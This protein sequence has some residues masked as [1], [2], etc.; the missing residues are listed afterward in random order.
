MLGL[1]VVSGLGAMYGTSQ[2]L[3][4]P[5]GNAPVEMQDVV[6]AARD[7]KLEEV[8]KDDPEMVKIERMAKTA[9]PV[10]AFSQVK[11]VE[12]RWVEISILAGEPIIDKKLAARGS[13]PGLISRI[14]VGM[15]A[16]AIEVSEKTGVSGFILP[17]HRVDVVQINAG[18]TGEPEAQTVLQDV[19]VLASGTVFSRPEDR[20]I[21][22]RTVT[23]AVTPEQ[24]D[25]L[26]GAQS[27]G[28][29]SL[30]LRGL[31]DHTVVNYKKHEPLPE[32][33]PPP[34][35]PIEVAVKEPEPPPPPEPKPEPIRVPPARKV[36]IYRG[37]DNPKP[38]T[39]GQAAEYSQANPQLPSDPQFPAGPQN[40]VDPGPPPADPPIDPGPMSP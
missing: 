2:M 40:Q 14:P 27:R 16:F 20:S 37:V 31:E 33:T 7:L 24:V 10:G 30:S 29:L 35:P 9:V 5:T 18:P 8:L 11:D 21:Q 1:A 26:V 17:D 19:Q 4:R 39:P 6:V 23:L 36:T 38:Y 15:R 25:T 13:P 32:P 34:P 3:G 12:D 28:P 22:A